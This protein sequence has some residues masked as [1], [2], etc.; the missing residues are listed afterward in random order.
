MKA[1]LDS[2]F[3]TSRVLCDAIVAARIAGC[4]IAFTARRCGGPLPAVRQE[5]RREGH[6]RRSGQR[7]WFDTLD[8]ITM[9]DHA[10]GNK[11]CGGHRRRQGETWPRG[12][13][14]SDELQQVLAYRKDS[15]GPVPLSDSKA[16]TDLHFTRDWVPGT[17]DRNGRLMTGTECNYIVAHGG[18]LYAAVS[19]WNHDPAAP[20]PDPEC[21]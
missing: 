14:L 3:Q 8:L 12:G 21:W 2:N 10:G 4:G 13:R 18:R 16:F 17:K 15:P 19:V 9:G 1:R 11:A 20:I 5:R 7:S 6:P